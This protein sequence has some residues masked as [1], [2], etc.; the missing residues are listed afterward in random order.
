MR[1]VRRLVILL[2]VALP[3]GALDEPKES[4]PAFQGKTLD[5]ETFNNASLKGK[6]V[7]LQFWA[8]WCGYCRRDQPAMDEIV[9]EY[10]DRGVKVLAVSVGESRKTVERYLARSPRACK[11]VLTEH[12]NLAS[13][14]ET[15]GFPMYVVIDREGRIA[16]QQTGAGGSRQLRALLARAGIE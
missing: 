1:T 6:V 10:A 9:S 2:A 13:R 11:I 7:L 16:A 15:Q 5:G 8:T 12:T 14:F 4:A 3:L